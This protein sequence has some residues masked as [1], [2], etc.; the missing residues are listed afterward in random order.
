[1][2]NYEILNKILKNQSLNFAANANKS[3][4]ICV[5]DLD[6]TLFNVSPRTQKIIE[7]FAEIHQITALKSVKVEPNHWGL[8]ESLIDSGV[9]LDFSN[10]NELKLFESLRDS[11]KL[12]FFSNDYLHYDTP[13]LGAVHFV[14]TLAENNIP[15]FYLTGR[16][17]NRMGLGTKE[18]L[19]K[20]GFP[21]KE[22]R[23]L[24]LKP[25]KDIDDKIFKF[26]WVHKLKN[27]NPE[28]I[29]YFFENEPV[30][31]NKIGEVHPDIEIIFLNTTHSRQQD[32]Q[33]PVHTMEHFDLNLP[34]NKA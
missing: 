24:N 33:V 21:I 1:M 13:Y 26:D 9:E 6:S 32:V 3:N 25:H 23:Y 14:Q 29:I 7:E 19:L 4:S 15:T 34:E 16:D 5:F 2:H 11:W 22:E 18:V 8:K 30:N 27:E 17:Q 31:I 20:W 12:K 28:S 10:P